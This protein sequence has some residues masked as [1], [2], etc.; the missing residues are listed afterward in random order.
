MQYDSHPITIPEFLREEL[1]TKNLIP[2]HE[3]KIT[4]P[5]GSVSTGIVYSGIAGYG[6]YYQIRFRSSRD[7]SFSGLSVHDAV[8]VDIEKVSDNIT[9]ALST[10]TQL[11][12]TPVQT[13]TR[14]AYPNAIDLEYVPEESER[15]EVSISRIIR[16]TKLSRSIKLLYNFRCQLCKTR[17]EFPDGRGYAE[18]HHIKPLGTPH[19][20]PDSIDNMLCLC[21][22]CHAILDF[23]INLIELK[24]LNYDVE[25]HVV[26]LEYINYH[27]N[28][29]YGQV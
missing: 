11:S 22:N 10:V 20:G 8:R 5:D 1:E 26:N 2:Q 29:I 23:G 21:P 9:I 14:P 27:N 18:T 12:P 19:N 13:N 3:I 17:I 6:P 24:K 28:F 7:G 25:K 4:C 16:D 15:Q